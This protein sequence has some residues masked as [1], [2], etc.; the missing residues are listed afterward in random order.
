MVQVTELHSH[1]LLE[2]HVR[3]YA[4]QHHAVQTAADE[5]HHVYFQ[6]NTLRLQQPNVSVAGQFALPF[7]SRVT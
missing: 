6:T 7:G 5:T 4:I 1:P 2:A 3:L